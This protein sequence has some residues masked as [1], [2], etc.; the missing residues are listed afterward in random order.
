LKINIYKTKNQTKTRWK[1]T[2]EEPRCDSCRK[3][4]KCSC[5]KWRCRR[6]RCSD[7]GRSSVAGGEIARWQ[8]KVGGRR[9]GAH[10][11]VEGRRN[12]CRERETHCPIGGTTSQSSMAGGET[13]QWQHNDG[14]RTRALIKL[15]GLGS[16]DNRGI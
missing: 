2:L 7:G 11:V 3:K 9:R 5:T 16:I 14:R 4:G 8:H 1:F 12:S 13:W 15:Y 10:V 6:K